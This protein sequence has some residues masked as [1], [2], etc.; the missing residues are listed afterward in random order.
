[1]A[2][3]FELYHIP[4]QSRR[5]KLRV[6]DQTSFISST[7]DNYATSSSIIDDHQDHCNTF[8]QDHYLS[9]IQRPLAL[10]LSSHNGTHPFQ[11]YDQST[12]CYEDMMLG[13]YTGYASILKGSKF[14]N[15]AKQLLDEIC[16]VGSFGFDHC[17]LMM[18]MDPDP[19]SLQN[20]RTNANC[21]KRSSLISLLDE[22]YKRY[23]H[24]Y[25]QIQAVIASFETVAGLSSA[26]PFANLDLKA[27]SKSFRCLNNAI[28]DQLQFSVKPHEHQIS[29][30]REELVWSGSPN[31]ELY[32]QRAAINNMGF[33]DH[34]PVWRPQRGLPK[35]A[36]NV[37]RAWLFDHF[38]HPYP[39]DT[40]KQIL[41]KQTGLSRNQ[42]SNWFINARVRV[43]KPMVEE[44]H[45]LEARQVHER[46]SHI[47]EQE[48]S[49][50]IFRDP[51]HRMNQDPPSK[52]PRIDFP[53]DNK[54]NDDHIMERNKEHMNFYGNFS[55]HGASNGGDGN[56]GVSLT[57]GLHQ[58]DNAITFSEPFPLTGERFVIGGLDGQNRQVGQEI[59]RGQFLHDFG[60]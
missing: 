15:P 11:K 24:Y 2:E 9:F 50:V 27:M 21:R 32:G 60:G 22:V 52:R 12:S 41:A 5:D 4:Q 29:Y 7:T 16:D 25:Q 20:L 28:T 46:S 3:G 6:G 54:Y 37:L 39:T 35:R 13:P 14:L 42:V 57:L 33:V 43:W 45:T 38:L 34:Q 48:A 56:R 47:Q 40:D 10:S 19:P 36:V 58:N 23:K 55:I 1:M 17:G 44:V 30:G 53:F 26:A 31:N 49:A 18:E 59:I 51:S 8:L